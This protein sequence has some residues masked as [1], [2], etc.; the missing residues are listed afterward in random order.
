MI[1]HY[2]VDS[3]IIC[4]CKENYVCFSYSVNDKLVLNKINNKKHI[5]NIR[6]NECG[7]I[8]LK[9]LLKESYGMNV[10]GKI[11]ITLSRPFEWQDYLYIV[12]QTPHQ[13][14]DVISELQTIATH[15]HQNGDRDV[16]LFVPTKEGAFIAERENE[17]Y[18]LLV[19]LFKTSPKQKKIGRKLA[20]MHVRGRTLPHSVR[21]VNRVGQWKQL[22]EQRLEQMEKVWNER[23]FQL[24]ENDFERMFFESFPY[25]MGLTENAIQYLVDTE[26]DDEPLYSDSGTVCH[27]RF[28]KH[29]WGQLYCLKNPFDWVLDHCSRDLAEWTRECYFQNKQTYRPLIQNFYA[30]YQSI[31]RLSSFSWRLLY[32]RLLFPLHYF[33]CIENYYMFSIDHQKKLQEENLALILKQTNEYEGFLRQF[34]QI[35]EVP[36]S[37]YNIPTVDWLS[38]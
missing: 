8:C 12:V 18:C 15:L 22:W 17:K 21:S 14:V 19:N 13:T 28:S 33:E 1:V 30:N 7:G 26:I 24:P 32:S 11:E 9:R 36:V 10:S 38:I 35:C 3:F 31:A 16:C 34:Y 25:F 20:K 29:S 27:E 37:A 23:V 5:L 6:M 4:I 2:A